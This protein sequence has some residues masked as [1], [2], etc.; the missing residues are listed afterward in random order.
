MPWWIN[1]T[2]L[3]VARNWL[4][5]LLFIHVRLINMSVEILIIKYAWM[6]IPTSC[7]PVCR[8]NPLSL[9]VCFACFD[10]MLS[11]I[12]PHLQTMII[13]HNTKSSCKSQVTN[14]NIF[15]SMHVFKIQL[16][17]HVVAPLD[18]I[19]LDGD[20]KVVTW[21]FDVVFLWYGFIFEQCCQV[22]VCRHERLAGLSNLML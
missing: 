8:W 1:G 10:N 14:Y 2:S 18:Y 17:W 6:Y 3:D 5:M 15:P 7:H 21:G 16:W 12:R 11:V 9:C 20:G 22:L 4:R 13:I 19:L